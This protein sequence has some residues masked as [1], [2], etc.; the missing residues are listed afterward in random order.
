MRTLWRGISR[1]L[2][3]S[4]ERGSWP[5]DA[6]VVAIL[7]FV[8]LTPRHWFNDQPRSTPPATQAATAVRM[9]A[10]DDSAKTRTYRLSADMLPVSKRASKPSPELEEQ[11][12]NVL[13]RSVDDLKNRTFQV[14]DIQIIR[15][16]DGSIN[17][18]D[19]SVKL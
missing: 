16:D 15:G 13:S 12:H 4:Y 2:F 6:M 19:V 18:Y 3:W 17:Y 5:Y 11:T 8:L 7:I 10:H 14:G 1:T 9:I